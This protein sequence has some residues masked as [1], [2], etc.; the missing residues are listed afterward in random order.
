MKIGSMLLALTMIGCS[1]DEANHYFI[2]FKNVRSLAESSPVYCNG[3]T[4]GRVESIELSENLEVIVGV[5]INKK[6]KLKKSLQFALVPLSSL[7][8][9]AIEVSGA[10]EGDYL[11]EWD[12]INGVSIVKKPLVD[13][14]STDVN[15]IMDSILKVKF[16]PN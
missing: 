5:E 11:N 4:I 3:V 16:K 12:T 2:R 15:F 9:Q 6:V 10:M 8:S 1:H 14:D 7:G 13:I